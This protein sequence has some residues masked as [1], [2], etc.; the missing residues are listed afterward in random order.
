MKTSEDEA[1]KEED[2][3][4]MQKSLLKLADVEEFSK[5]FFM[6]PPKKEIE[7]EQVQKTPIG[8]ADYNVTVMHHRSTSPIPPSPISPDT[9]QSSKIINQL[10]LIKN[11][12]A[13]K[14]DQIHKTDKK[15]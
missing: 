3:L 9:P 14:I 15:K 8:Q 5:E 6:T 13:G 11:G 1:P 12:I 4:Q 7:A 10:Q 2:E